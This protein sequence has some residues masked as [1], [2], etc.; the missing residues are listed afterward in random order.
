MLAQGAC[1]SAKASDRS[2][3]ILEDVTDVIEETKNNYR[4]VLR[5]THYR[6]LSEINDLGRFRNSEVAQELLHNLSLLEYQNAKGKTWFSLHPIVKSL[7]EEG[8]VL[9]G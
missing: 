3:V 9:E 6:E 5:D 1:V 8:Q 2:K 4:R 7:L